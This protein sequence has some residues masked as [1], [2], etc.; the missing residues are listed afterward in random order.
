M[1]PKASQAA[2]SERHFPR[3]RS[4]DSASIVLGRVGMSRAAMYAMIRALAFP[5][6]VK[7]GTR[8]FWD[9]YAIDAWIDA[10]IA[11]QANADVTKQA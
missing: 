4:L 7:I 5:A 6:P 2:F 9:S 8:S 3:P 11:E 10:R 1:N